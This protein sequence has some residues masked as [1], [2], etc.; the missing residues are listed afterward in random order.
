LLHHS[1]VSVNVIY[2]IGQSLKTPSYS[3]KKKF[4]NMVLSQ[5]FLKVHRT[6]DYQVSAGLPGIFV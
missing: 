3:S 1:I 5:E 6:L 2:M 4:E